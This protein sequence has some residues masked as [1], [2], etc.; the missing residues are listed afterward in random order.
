MADLDGWASGDGVAVERDQTVFGEAAQHIVNAFVAQARQLAAQDPAAGDV[1]LTVADLD[2]SKQYLPGSGAREVVEV[3]VHVLG[4]SREC[5]GRAAEVEIGAECERFPGAVVE[6]LCECVLEQ[7]QRGDVIRH[8]RHDLG[9]QTSFEAD[10]DDVGGTDD[11]EL[12]V[13]GR[14]RRDRFRASAQDLPEGVMGERTIVEV[15]PE[16]DDDAYTVAQVDDECGKGV[17]ERPANVRGGL[18]EDLLE[19]IHDEQQLS[20]VIGKTGPDAAPQTC[21]PVGQQLA[22]IRGRVDGDALQASGEGVEGVLP[23]RGLHQEP[24]GGPRQ[25][26]RVERG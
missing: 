4:A 10:S 8:V 21:R 18:G 26:T 14:H 20:L 1:L 24:F 15:S 6:E 25:R 12:E 9:Y 7:G 22:E 3:L 2:E 16:R 5:A 19:L 13:L 17:E 23:G 11:G